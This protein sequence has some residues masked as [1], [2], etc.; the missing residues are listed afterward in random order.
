MTKTGSVN[1]KERV[2]MKEALEEEDAE[3]GDKLN[4]LGVAGA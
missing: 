3:F 2:M 1:S 4:V